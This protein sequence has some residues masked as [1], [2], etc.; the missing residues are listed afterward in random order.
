M[1]LAQPHLLL[2]HRD[3]VPRAEIETRCCHEEVQAVQIMVLAIF[4][5]TTAERSHKPQL[6]RRGVRRG[7]IGWDVAIVVA[8]LLT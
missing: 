4:I 1:S 2:T 6:R 7:R 3:V 8:A 5:R